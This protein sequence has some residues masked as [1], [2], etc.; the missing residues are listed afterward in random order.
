MNELFWNDLAQKANPSQ[1]Y[2]GKRWFIIYVWSWRQKNNFLNRIWQP[3]M[4]FERVWTAKINAESGRKMFFR[5]IKIYIKKVMRFKKKCNFKRNKKRTE[6]YTYKYLLFLLTP[7][8]FLTYFRLVISKLFNVL[9]KRLKKLGWSVDMGKSSSMILSQM[10]WSTE[11]FAYE[12]CRL[13]SWSFDIF[14][15]NNSRNVNNYYLSLDSSILD[16]SWAFLG[17]FSG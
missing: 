12:H 3:S 11:R 1:R 8:H 13:V 2:I 6:T 5:K 14:C 7:R 15:L 17:F 16:I 9:K 4:V 10:S